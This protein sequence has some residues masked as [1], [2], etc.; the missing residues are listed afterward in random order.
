MLL[1]I[2]RSDGYPEASAAPIGK[3]IRYSNVVTDELVGGHM[4]FQL[5]VYS[6]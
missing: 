2:I 4:N 5:L 6:G 1:L 3:A